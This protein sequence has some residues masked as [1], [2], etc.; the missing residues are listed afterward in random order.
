MCMCMG[1]KY[2]RTGASRSQEGASGDLELELQLAGSCLTRPGDWESN[3]SPLQEQKTLLAA[4]VSLQ[5][6]LSYYLT[7]IT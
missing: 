3:S 6:V 4:E 1:Y 7:V 5:T 2:L